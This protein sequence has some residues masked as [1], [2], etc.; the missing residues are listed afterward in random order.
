MSVKALIKN[1][2]IFDFVIEHRV[3]VAVRNFEAEWDE[4]GIMLK[5]EHLALVVEVA[6]DMIEVQYKHS[7]PEKLAD[8][9]LSEVWYVKMTGWRM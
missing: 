3:S 6:K 4:R 2:D 8:E 7:A 1:E 9:M 5:H